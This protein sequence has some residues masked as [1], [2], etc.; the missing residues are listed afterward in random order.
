MSVPPEKPVETPKAW[1][2]FAEGDLT[3][4]KRGTK[5]ITRVSYNLFSVPKRG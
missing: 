4:A 5:R 3:V 1:M 2:R